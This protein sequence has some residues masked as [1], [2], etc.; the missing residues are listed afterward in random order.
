MVDVDVEDDDAVFV[1]SSLTIAFLEVEAATPGR[2][3]RN[4][5]ATPPRFFLGRVVALVLPL[6]I[7]I[8]DADGILDDEVENDAP[9]LSNEEV[10]GWMVRPS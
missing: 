6:P 2:R 8:V 1:S 4:N 5:G 7:I 3:C 9:L 10:V